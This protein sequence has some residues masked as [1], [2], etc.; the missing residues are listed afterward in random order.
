M[1]ILDFDYNHIIIKIKG[2]GPHRLRPTQSKRRTL[3]H[4]I[5][6]RPP[7]KKKRFKKK[8]QWFRKK[9]RKQADV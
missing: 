4:L 2:V 1:E 7:P 6:A 8:R 9:E 3:L 5:L